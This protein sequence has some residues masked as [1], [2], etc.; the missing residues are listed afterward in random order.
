MKTTT[1]FA[2]ALAAL[3]INLACLYQTSNAQL[4]SSDGHSSSCAGGCSHGGGNHGGGNDSIELI[5]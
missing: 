4:H 3:A 5:P 2:T 1:Y